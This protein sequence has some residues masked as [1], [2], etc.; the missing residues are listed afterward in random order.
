MSLSTDLLA[1]CCRKARCVQQGSPACCCRPQGQRQVQGQ[2]CHICYNS[3]PSCQSAKYELP[4]YEQPTTSD[5]HAPA[6]PPEQ[7]DLAGLCSKIYVGD[8]SASL[9]LAWR[10]HQGQ[11][12]PQPDKLS[13]THTANGHVAA[14]TCTSHAVI[15]TSGSSQT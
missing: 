11:F 13:C 7:L 10:Y 5:Q 14:A 3:P 9:V 4:L 12:K 2:G 15:N 6:S 1:V 8:E